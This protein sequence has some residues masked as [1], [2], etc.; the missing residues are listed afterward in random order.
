MLFVSE[1]VFAVG[2]VGGY[3]NCDFGVGIDDSCGRKDIFDIGERTFVCCG[4][5]AFYVCV[6]VRFVCIE[7]KKAFAMY[8]AGGKEKFSIEYAE[9]IYTFC[10][11]LKGNVVKYA[12][13][14]IVSVTPYKNLPVL[15]LI[16]KQIVVCPNDANTRQIFAGYLSAKNIS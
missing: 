3:G 14:D 7:H 1:V 9:G 16:S 8:G 13:K 5:C 12:A 10:N 6:C 15:E 11:I 2:G 4:D